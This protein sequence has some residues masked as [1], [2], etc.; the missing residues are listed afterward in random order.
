[1]RPTVQIELKIYWQAN[2][3][4]LITSVGTSKQHQ[5]II[6]KQA[7]NRRARVPILSLALSSSGLALTTL[8]GEEISRR[9]E[10]AAGVVAGAA[11]FLN[12]GGTGDNGVGGAEELCRE[13]ESITMGPYMERGRNSM[14]KR[15][16]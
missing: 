4:C 1:M 14:V 7:A 5:S 11:L 3:S 16:R 9:E 12:R 6:L 10:D 13:E 8:T 2:Y 15:R